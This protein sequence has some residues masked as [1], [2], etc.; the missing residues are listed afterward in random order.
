MGIHANDIVGRNVTEF[1]PDEAE[2]KFINKHGDTDG[3]V[4]AALSHLKKFRDKPSEGIVKE[5][6]RV[7]VV[8][9]TGCEMAH[10]GARFYIWGIGGPASCRVVT[11]AVPDNS[12]VKKR[13][14]WSRRS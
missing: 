4:K 9:V 2:S 14:R 7:K 1:T 11:Q 13:R 6:Y 8:P 12:K 10:K 5:D 3:Y